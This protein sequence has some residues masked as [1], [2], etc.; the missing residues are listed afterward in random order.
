MILTPIWDRIWQTNEFDVL[1]FRRREAEIKGIIIKETTL[2]PDGC[3]QLRSPFCPNLLLS[4]S[5]MFEHMYGRMVQS[6]QNKLGQKLLT[7][8]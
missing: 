7:V 4:D 3:N 1:F 5:T 2:L 6:N 8:S